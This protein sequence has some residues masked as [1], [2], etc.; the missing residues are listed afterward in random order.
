MN[1]HAFLF[2]PGRWIGEGKITFSTSSELIRFYT[3]WT[4]HPIEGNKMEC[5]Q[6]VE[7]QGCEEKI[8][9]KFFVYDVSEKGFKIELVN[10]LVGK[11]CGTGVIDEKKIAWE[12]HGQP[13]IEGFEVYELQ[14]N[15][16]Y[17]IHAEYCAADPLR[18]AIDARI[19]QKEATSST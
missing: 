6:H 12:F 1:A 17:M 11:A 7:L 2:L 10:D 3:S 4:I 8:N 13:H 5:H 16:D 14:E 18:T 9:N 15:G 19:W